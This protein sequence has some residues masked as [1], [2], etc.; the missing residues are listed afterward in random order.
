MSEADI[1]LVANPL[2]HGL[3]PKEKG[4]LA[5]TLHQRVGP[6]IQASLES[7]KSGYLEWNDDR[8]DVLITWLLSDVSD[9]V[10]F[11]PCKA[12]GHSL[13]HH[14]N[15]EGPKPCGQCG[16][17]PFTPSVA[18][19]QRDKAAPVFFGLSR[20][21]ALGELDSPYIKAIAFALIE[22]LKDLMG[23]SLGWMQVRRLDEAPE[24]PPDGTRLPAVP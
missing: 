14:R 22:G 3:T 10:Q 20:A 12:C 24:E 18:K 19:A 11:G 16:H 17:Y 4:E 7:S 6:R 1:S 9:M 21:Q 5:R 8:W 15:D 2:R 13:T 23:A